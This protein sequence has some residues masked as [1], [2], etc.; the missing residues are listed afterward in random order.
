LGD[1]SLCA[2]DQAIE[3]TSPA[4]CFCRELQDLC[5]V[6]MGHED[7]A[8][9]TLDKRADFGEGC[10]WLSLFSCSNCGQDWLVACEQ[11]VY[12]VWFL[13]RTSDEVAE[14]IVE[15]NRWPDVFHSY[16]EL[17]KLALER[18]HR[19]CYLDPADSIELFGA[20]EDLAKAK[21]N[22]SLLELCQLLPIDLGTA[23]KISKKVVVKTGA[24][25]DFTL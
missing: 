22:I 7:D 20:I 11:R 18:G 15:L 24:R 1:G 8:F 6:G 5:D 17:L 13:K 12:D 2:F 14:Q 9:R 16:A 21:P 19:V 25:I 23:R 3:V 4:A 10:W